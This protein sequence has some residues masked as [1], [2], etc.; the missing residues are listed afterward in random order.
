MSVFKRIV[1]YNKWQ[2]SVCEYYIQILTSE[3]MLYYN[4]KGKI[5]E[6]FFIFQTN[7]NMLG[8]VLYHA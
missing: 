3:N 1:A 2:E 5:G 7:N 8:T 4:S 6:F